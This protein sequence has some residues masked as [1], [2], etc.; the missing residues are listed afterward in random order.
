MRVKELK[1]M[2]SIVSKCGS[3][4]KFITNQNQCREDSKQ[5]VEQVGDDKVF[6]ILVYL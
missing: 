3:E 4:S 6:L 5:Q 1:D 2:I